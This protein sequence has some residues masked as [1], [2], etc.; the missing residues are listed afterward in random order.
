[1]KIIYF[2]KS[3]VNKVTPAYRAQ[4]KSTVIGNR[5][6]TGKIEELNAQVLKNNVYD[7]LYT[8]ILFNKYL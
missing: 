8:I 4:P 2:F 3:I 6:D 7:T 5:G 1:M